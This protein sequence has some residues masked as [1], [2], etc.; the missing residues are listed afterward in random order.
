MVPLERDTDTRSWRIDEQSAASMDLQAALQRLP[1]EQV[2][3]L[4]LTSYSGYT[5]HEAAEILGT[6]P[7]AVR[8]R[9]C[10]AMRALRAVMVE[11]RDG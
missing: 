9:V 8:Q 1:A 4:M 11:R 6:T 5:S 7:D 3:A 2:S 10:R